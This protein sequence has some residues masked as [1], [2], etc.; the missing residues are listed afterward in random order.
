MGHRR[1][2]WRTLLLDGLT[3][4]LLAAALALLVRERLLPALA[5]REIA[6]PGERIPADLLLVDA[7]TGDT[8]ALRDAGPVVLLAVLSTCPSCERA[9]PAWRRAVAASGV[10]IRALLVGDGESEAAWAAERLPGAAPLRPADPGPFL[11]RTR[12][13]VVPTA[14]AIGPDGRLLAR[15]EGILNANEIEALR[16]AAAAPLRTAP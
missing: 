3:G 16:S 6:D 13:R 10:R 9:M 1:H 8:L 14:L 7:A 5:E 4:L 11:R 12:I 15:R 2:G